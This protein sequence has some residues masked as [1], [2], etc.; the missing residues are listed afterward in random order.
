MVNKILHIIED[1]I[2]K[3]KCGKCNIYQSLDNYNKSSNTWDKLRSECKKC[4]SERR[5]ADKEKMTEYNKIYWQKTKEIQKEKNK[6]W[7]EK[8]KDHVKNKMREWLEANK[9]YKKQK[10]K[11]Y[12]EVNWEKK[13][14]YCRKWKQQDYID[15]KSNP[16]RINEYNTYK[17]KSNISRRIREL[18]G[19][20]KSKSSLQYLGCSLEQFKNH[21]QA[22]FQDGMS[23]DNYGCYKKGDTKS[24][25]HLD[26]IIPC[27]AFNL[28]D[29]YEQNACF[30][31]LNLQPLWGKDNII[32][33]DFFDIKDKE[34]YMEM[35]NNIIENI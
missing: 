34:K 3:K 24:G 20:E 13:K 18:I 2:E 15:L 27:N 29:K 31:Y 28:E 10:D 4:L 17:I 6:Q 7:R 30:Y 21:I 16:D 33:S 5:I 1:N 25:W 23:W 26:H 32:K 19:Q 11:E 12:N 14:E 9:E 8:N 35:Y 22:Q